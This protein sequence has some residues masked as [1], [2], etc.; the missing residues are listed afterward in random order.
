MSEE[1]ITVG[2]R[3]T[4][5]RGASIISNTTPITQD[6]LASELSKLSTSLH[7]SLNASIT[8]SVTQAVTEALKGE[9]KGLA[10]RVHSVEFDVGSIQEE[11][12]KRD[13]VLEERLQ[14]IEAANLFNLIEANKQQQ[15]NRDRTTKI[16]NFISPTTDSLSLQGEV[17]ALIIKPA[18]EKAKDAG[19]ILE[20]PEQ[21]QVIEHGHRLR[22]RP[23]GAPAS[24]LV[25]FTTRGW[26]NLYIEFYKEP[27]AAKF[28][29]NAVDPVPTALSHPDFR[30]GRDLTM[31]F[32]SC[33]SYLYESKD[34][35][36]V[37]L[38]GGSVQFTLM[39]SNTWRTVHNPY[40]TCLAEMQTVVPRPGHL[41]KILTVDDT[42]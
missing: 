33:M 11:Q 14:A 3:R 34:V 21:M 38:A 40:G 26:Y 6:Y 22:P 19:K 20:V 8:L 27:L 32:R 5:P 30:I 36:K 25:V 2:A 28:A 37:K 23:G 29:P 42:A 7:L 4:A 41:A 12:V 15:R 17:F 24:L 16:H 9:I 13:K 31:V 10:D 39:R 35:D 18:F 1:N